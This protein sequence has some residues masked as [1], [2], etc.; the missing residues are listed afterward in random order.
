MAGTTNGR[1]ETPVP[2]DEDCDSRK[3]PRIATHSVVMSRALRTTRY[4]DYNHLPC[5]C[6]RPIRIAAVKE[7]PT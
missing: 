3:A 1:P 4:A 5:N 2:H 7:G 6:T